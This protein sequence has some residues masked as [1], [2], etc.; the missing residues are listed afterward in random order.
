MTTRHPSTR[1]A[2]KELTR[3]ALAGAALKL[4]A[5]NSFDS[6]SLREVTRAAGITP[7]AFYRHYD[8][9]EE[10]GLSLVEESFAALGAM[11]KEARS[12]AS[13]DEDAIRRSLAV[14]VRHLND[15]TAHF[16]FIARER[17]GGMRRVR[18]AINQ[19]LQLFTDE[20][21]MD[22]VVVPGV[23]H[24]TAADRRILAGVI[25]EAIIGMVAELLEAAPG[26]EQGII[27]R[28]ERL[29]RLI[30][31]GVPAWH[32]SPTPPVTPPQQAAMLP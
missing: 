19:E 28:T 4:L 24:W 31:L 21:A 32:V 5:D 13:F 30:S 2:G 1:L 26:E 18:R 3:Q 15:R 27:D 7:T 12:E 25:A 11:L 9:M 29:L 20:L 14:V 23:D 17:Y 6:L 10:L 8:G 16:R 22:L